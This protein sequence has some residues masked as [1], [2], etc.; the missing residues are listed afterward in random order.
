MHIPP[1][2]PSLLLSWRRFTAALIL[3][4]VALNGWA[5]SP[6]ALS[7]DAITASQAR[8]SWTNIPGSFVLEESDSLSPTSAWR[9]S[10]QIPTLLNERYFVT[11]DFTGATRFFRLHQ[12]ATG[13]LPPDPATVAPPLPEG[14]ATPLVSATEF[15]YSGPNPIQTGVTNGIIQLQR[16]AVLRGKARGAPDGPQPSRIRPNSQPRGRHVRPGGER[17]QLRDRAL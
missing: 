2:V 6:P 4:G 1:L 12:Q 14:T 13:P 3:A 10:S 7:V 8:I 16:A 17:R 9:P 11:V 5:Q 15:L